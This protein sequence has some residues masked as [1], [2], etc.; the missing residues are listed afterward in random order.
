MIKNKTSADLKSAL[1]F[2]KSYVES[3]IK[4]LETRFQDNDLISSFKFFNPSNMPS[5]RVG[6]A[7]C[8]VTEL[9][10]LL[11]HYKVEKEVGVKLFYHL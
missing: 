11:K 10:L 1:F 2:H 9:E 7:S 8:G 3:I 5:R 6:L 4:A